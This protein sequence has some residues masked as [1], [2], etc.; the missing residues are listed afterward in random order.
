[1]AF[2]KSAPVVNGAGFF[3]VVVVTIQHA[4]VNKAAWM[5]GKPEG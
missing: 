5:M 2:A 3:V 4:G 1:M